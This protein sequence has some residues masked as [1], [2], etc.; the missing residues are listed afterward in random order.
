MYCEVYFR[1]A[2]VGGS[3]YILDVSVCT[4]VVGCLCMGKTPWICDCE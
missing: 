2:G 3:G 1:S 4:L